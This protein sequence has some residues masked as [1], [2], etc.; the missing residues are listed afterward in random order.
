MIKTRTTALGLGLAAVLAAAPF[1]ADHEG[2][3]LRTYMDPVGIPTACMGETDQT[4]TVRERFSRDECMAVLGASLTEHAQGLAECVTTPLKPH[5]AAAVLSWTYN[6]GVGAACRSTL[7]RKL[8]AGAA[9]AEW[10]AE[11]KRWNRAG[12]RVLP[13]LTLRREREFAMCTGART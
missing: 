9:P 5:E 6:V 3:M 1:V 10:C 2:V 8:N 11:L 4:I 12:D 7:V 13:G